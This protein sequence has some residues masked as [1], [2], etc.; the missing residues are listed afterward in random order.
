MS[1][2]AQLI[3][4]G[5]DQNRVDAMDIRTHADVL[6]HEHRQLTTKM[7]TELV[8]AIEDLPTPRTIHPVERRMIDGQAQLAEDAHDALRHGGG[9]QP[10]TAGI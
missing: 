1:A 7:L 5:T 2:V 10:G 6:Q 9:C 8:Q 3:D 4:T